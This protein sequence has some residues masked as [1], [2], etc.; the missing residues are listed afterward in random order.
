MATDEEVR[1]L[2]DWLPALW[3]KVRQLR[4]DQHIFN[5]TQEVIAS[6]E[7]LQRPSHFFAWMQD[8]YVSGMAM[9]VRRLMDDD[10]RTR[11]LLQFLLRLRSDPDAVSR[12]RYQQLYE[13]HGQRIDGDFMKHYVDHTYDSYVG[14]GHAA[15]PVAQIQG[16]LDEL[17]ERTRLFI[18]FGNKV[19]GH[20]DETPPKK[21]PTF[22][23]LEDV[24][25]TMESILQRYTQLLT[26]THR[27]VDINWQYDWKAIFRV[28]W[29]S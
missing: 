22:A 10:K 16:Q 4:I 20:A 8:M 1:V 14:A 3:P 28:P 26:A 13:Q 25:A 11:S 15:P 19:I 27:S 2:R 23:E 18:D 12:E 7:A 9:A 17:R 24:I 29:I 6:N 21:L 5:E